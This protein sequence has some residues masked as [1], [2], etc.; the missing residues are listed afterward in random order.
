MKRILPIALLMMWLLPA[1]S[2]VS[3]YSFTFTPATY[4]PITGGTVS[5]ATGDSGFEIINL[6]FPFYYDGAIYN[7][8]S[9][10]TNGVM[11]M[12][13][14]TNSLTSNNLSSSTS[15]SVL[16][17]LWDDLNVRT[18]DTAEIR[19]ET[20]GTAPNRFFVVQWT[21]ARWNFSSSSGTFQDFQI[22][23]SEAD[24]SIGFVYGT[25]NTPNNPSAS[26]GINGNSTGSTSF[27]SVTP[28]GPATV[29]S[30]SANNNIGSN[31]GLTNNAFV[32]TPPAGDLAAV[33]LSSPTLG[34]FSNME[35]ITVS[36][37]NSA[38]TVDFSVDS[39]VV[40]VII[41]GPNPDTIFT[42]VNAGMLMPFTSQNVTVTSTYDMS[43]AGTY[44]FVPIASLTG[45]T[46][47]GNDTGSVVSLTANANAT[48]PSAVDF[49]GFTGSN[50][51][52][53]FS[54]WREGDGL[55]LPLGTSSSWTSQTGL[56]GS[57]NRTARINLFTDNRTEW[58][59]GPQFVATATDLVQY[60]V[61][62]TNFGS[63]T[64]PDVMGSDDKLYVM[65]STD[66]GGS[67]FPIDSIDTANALSTTLTQRTVS[68]SAYAGQ[69]VIVAF[70]ATDGP[71]NDPED[72]DLHLD[73]IF[74]GTPPSVDLATTA[75]VSPVAPGCL[76]SAETVEVT[77]QNASTTT[78]DFSVD[79]AVVSVNIT[80][81]N[82]T[83]LNLTLNSGTLASGASQ[84]VV[85]ST[86]Y[87]MSASG[88]YDFEASVNATADGLNT[89]DTLPVVSLVQNIVVLP[90]AVDFT[91]FSGNN[92]P[93]L[94]S[95]WSEAGGT[96]PPSGTTSIWTD[97]DDLGSVGNK[98]AR[99]NLYD[100]FQDGWIVSP[101]FVATATDTLLYK[102]AVT[103]WDD[104]TPS[105]MGSD[106]KLYV[107]L[108]LD[109]GI[110]WT[111]I[112]SVDSNDAI[113]N[114]LTQRTVSL[115]TYAGQ[116][117]VLAFYG[118]DG[119]V[120]DAE[121]IDVHIDDIFIGTPPSIDIAATG[122]PTPGPTG[123]YTANQTVELEITNNHPN[124]IDFSVDTL[125]AA[126]IVG[127]VNPDTL[128]TFVNSG[129]LA[130]GASQVVTV[131]TT[132]D[133]SAVGTYTFRGVI[134]VDGDGNPIN[135]STIVFTRTQ[136]ALAS[137]PQQLDFTGYT[138]ANLNTLYPDWI[139]TEDFP[140]P[141]G[142]TSA[143]TDQDDLG[144][145]GN[146]TARINLYSDFNEEWLLGPRFTAGVNS[147]LS[148]KVAVTNWNSVTVG[149]AMGSDD[150]MYV[151]L[152]NDCG[153]SWIAIDSVDAS[154]NLTTTLTTRGVTLGT[155]AGQDVI[156]GFFAT[157]GTVDDTQD[158]DLHLDDI[159]IYTAPSNDVGVI[160]FVGSGSTTICGEEEQ[161]FA[162]VIQNF[163][164]NTQTTFPVNV[165]ITGSATL[166]L[167]A[168][169]SGIL[170]FLELDTVVVD[171]L[172]TTLGGIF[173]LNGY[174][175]MNTDTSNAND[176]T[177]LSGLTIF[178][179]PIF[180]LGNDTAVCDGDTVTFDAGAGFS[181]DWLNGADT[182][183]SISVDSAGSYFVMITD[184]NG[185]TNTDTVVLSINTLPLVALGADT[186]FCM[187]NSITLDAGNAG[188]TYSWNNGAA[189]AQTIVADTTGTYNVEVVDGNNCANDD[190]IV[191]TV[192]AN[193]TVALGAD[194]A[195][196]V[197]ASISLDAGAGL[198]AYSWNGGAA[199]TQTL[200]ADTTGSYMV[201]VTDSNNCSATDTLVLT[202]NALPMV[203][204]GNDTA[205]CDGN[206]T[207]LDAGAG[208]TY[209]WND[210]TTNQTLVVSTSGTYSVMIT[211]GNNC[212][213]LDSVVVTV[214]PLPTV[215]LGADRSFCDG[216]S[217]ILDGGSA[218][219]YL[220][221]DNSTNQTLTVMMA[222]TY[223]VT[224]TDANGCTASDDV[225]LTVS[226]LPVVNLGNDTTI[227]NGD[228]FTLDAGNAGSTYL[229]D[230]NSTAQTLAVSVTGTYSVTVTSADGCEGSDTIVVEIWPV[231]VNEILQQAVVAY[232]PN[233]TKGELTVEVAG[234]G[235]RNLTVELVNMQ[236]QVM[237]SKV[238]NQ[239]PAAFRAELN[240][241]GVAAGSYFL[242][243]QTADSVLI[244][245]VTVQ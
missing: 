92:L 94:F 60:K 71:V 13:S 162:V 177:L 203:N 207:T 38:D 45:D 72:Y 115:S 91:G 163:G 204:L 64:T 10:T 171:T 187:G 110:S 169:Y 22:V 101:Q 168:N 95:G 134:F 33:G 190:D 25:T 63:T 80:G 61:A 132:Y 116:N 208:F 184:G 17:P 211:D 111:P 103:E 195:V 114:V 223:S 174:T 222:G 16:A 86:T 36:I 242:R 75:L 175:A 241:E 69:Q 133:M 139:E 154:N 113:S 197:G 48:L 84:N 224:I 70:L 172:N 178:P 145:S 11:Q 141:S 5:S 65:L 97:Q 138:G 231:S 59:V 7:T 228:P 156:I 19:Y 234:L 216:L 170:G 98:T 142:T 53:V 152:S 31:T 35:T 18:A 67:Y 159:N 166:N 39:A 151:Y 149:D 1:M 205:F 240:L 123:C 200:T 199:T 74:I 183:Q 229:W 180:S 57:G 230:D 34:C 232:Y 117:V 153:L 27:L 128:I 89:N 245:K 20:Q 185:C 196:C 221:D 58:I 90:S 220:W 192:N 99:I 21:K 9:V 104:V 176:T 14:G 158:Y 62:V 173:N 244:K 189:T 93:S 239:I 217:E 3:N 42:T 105:P 87:D 107:M 144:F 52:S 143:W 219:S 160:D 213:N 6:G 122:I 157:D 112:D 51:N 54:D 88:T 164:V 76:T 50:L 66:C 233:P 125:T 55:P 212:S 37:T 46:I 68:L 24:M 118:T 129:T 237:S 2:Q 155:Y 226:P 30:T 8:A 131:S 23:L 148:Y 121:D 194:T 146:K 108:S 218:T 202:V 137:L 81:P 147:V 236:G 73:D 28:G 167:T 225:T 32:F 41:S 238:F 120:D 243:L 215:S 130:S 186:T 29:S 181:Y 126:V 56:G 179:Q 209:T 106:D 124:A 49:T 165:D 83:V 82:P 100:T 135:D 109:C 102:V 235:N 136:T 15:V 47:N 119:S 4:T 182:N 188:A 127:G 96:N 79:S 77:I 198:A 214:N 12:G 206:S 26:I 161:P 201:M 140:V 78:I 193:P 44:D 210:N 85:L 191:I 150:K 43:A 227:T 40:G